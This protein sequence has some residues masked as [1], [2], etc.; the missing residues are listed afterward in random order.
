MQP[1]LLRTNDHAWT[2]KAHVSNDLVRSESMTIN[3]ICPNE[4]ASTTEPCL[5]MDSDCLVLH[6]DHLVGKSN[7]F[8]DHVKRRTCPIIKDHVKV[9]DTQRGEIRG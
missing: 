4:T 3:E 2:H 7:E 5:A 8:L 1:M 6:S 9:V